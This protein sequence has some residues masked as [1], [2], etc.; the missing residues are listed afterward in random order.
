MNSKTKLTVLNF[1]E[2]EFESL[3]RRSADYLKKAQ[4]LEPLTKPALEAKKESSA[5]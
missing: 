4:K 5:A 2:T 1:P 3:L